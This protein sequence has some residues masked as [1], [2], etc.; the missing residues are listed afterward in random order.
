[1]AGV[2][3]VSRRVPGTYQEMMVRPSIIVVCIGLLALPA[4]ALAADTHAPPGNSEVGEY[5]E[6]V[7][8]AG[9][10]TPTRGRRAPKPLDP[11]AVLGARNANRLEALGTD[12]EAAARAIAA[13]AQDQGA[14]NGRGLDNSTRSG[15]PASDHSTPSVVSAIGKSLDGSSGGGLG[16]WLPLLLLASTAAAAGLG[17]HRRLQQK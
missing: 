6:T 2:T 1:M 5:L 13:A 16:I 11:A 8:G 3:R 14:G 12:G 4:P 15:E 9:G 10:N 7:P 17:L